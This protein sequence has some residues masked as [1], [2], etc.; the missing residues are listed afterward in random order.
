M[1]NTGEVI[2]RA[3]LAVSLAIRVA[4]AVPPPDITPDPA[5]R[6]W[7]ESLKQPRTN[8]PCCSIS[9]CHFTA[10]SLRNGRYEITVDGW[11]YVV[12]DEVIT[13]TTDNLVGKAVVC[14]TY[15]SFGPPM[16]AGAVRTAPQDPIRILCFVPPKRTS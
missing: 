10:Y 2:L 4:E 5:L 11:P 15:D 3:G 6:A 12:P 1:M 14:Y 9:D 16:P 7:F 13:N 8:L